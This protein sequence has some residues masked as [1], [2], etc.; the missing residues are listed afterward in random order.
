[1]DDPRKRGKDDRIRI[2]VSQAHERIYWCNALGITQK[3]LR[4]VVGITGPMVADVKAYLIN[5]ITHAGE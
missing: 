3:E 5:R 2:A 4:K 1:M